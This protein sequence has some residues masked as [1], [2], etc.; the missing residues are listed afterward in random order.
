LHDD[1]G[2]T[3]ATIKGIL[4]RAKERVIIAAELPEVGHAYELIDKASNDL[5]IITHDLMP[6]E[7]EHYTLPDVV[8]QLVERANQSST[9]AFEFI[10]FGTVRRLKPERELVV[11]RIIAELIQNALKHG[12]SGLAIVQ[13]G[14]HTRQLSILVETPLD[15]KRPNPLFSTQM[16]LGIGRKN[17]NYRAEYLRASLL[18]DCNSESYIVMLDVPYDAT[19]HP[20]HKHSDR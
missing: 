4:G 5:R 6:V 16:S 7:F 3:L 9:A 8:A 13:L 12:G 20:T 18:T 1:V 11:Y 15:P 19:I 17:I 10:V 2:N 14:Y